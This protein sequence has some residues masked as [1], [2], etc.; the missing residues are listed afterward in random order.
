[1]KLDYPSRGS[2]QTPSPPRMSAEPD[3]EIA[4]GEAMKQ[5]GLRDYYTKSQ[6]A[7]GDVPDT[8]LGT[9][10]LEQLFAAGRLVCDGR[11][12][13]YTVGSARRHG[14]RFAVQLRHPCSARLLRTSLPARHLSHQCRTRRS[15]C[16]FGIAA[17]HQCSHPFR[18]TRSHRSLAPTS[19]AVR[20]EEKA[21][22]DAADISISASTSPAFELKNPVIA[23]SGT[24]GYG[25][26]FEDVVHSSKLGGF[27]VKGLSREPMAG[28]PPPRL[29]G[30]SPP[31]C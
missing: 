8:E 5:A 10:I 27:V 17:G 19:T 21:S 11:S 7:A 30:N 29:M 3:A 22:H 20:L 2:I 1:M 24:F 6:L 12:R 23:A 26:E 13:L 15:G 31:A 16:N 18:R 25:V 28:N 4:V 9:E 14:S